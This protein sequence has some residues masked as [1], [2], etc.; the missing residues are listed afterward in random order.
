MI[1]LITPYAKGRDWAVRLEEEIREPVEVAATLREA[2]AKL[3]AHE[4]S[5]VVI[6]SVVP[7][8]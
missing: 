5:A 3:R 7:G 2:A 4:Y 8:S 1:L 6:E